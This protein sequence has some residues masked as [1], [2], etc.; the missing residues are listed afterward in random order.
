MNQII[1]NIKDRRSVRKYQSK[2]ITPE[3][4]QIIIDAGLW[5]PS[6]KNRKAVHITI[7]HGPDLIGRLGEELAAAVARAPENRYKELV[8]SPE[9]RVSFGA[10][11]LAIVSADAARALTPQEDC[12]CALQNIFLAARS[13]G[14]GSC[15]VNQLGSVA[16][17][18]A[19]ERF[20]ASAA[21]F[22]A[23]NTIYGAAALGYPEGG[24]PPA[25]RRKGAYNVAQ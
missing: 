1:Q 13:L 11:T 16:G 9:Y 21:G 15:W 19:F 2:Q 8:G 14:V 12:A 7:V 24:F 10:P 22:P 18:P 23:G 20:L 5:A 6:G 4:C 3:E 25:P 17:D